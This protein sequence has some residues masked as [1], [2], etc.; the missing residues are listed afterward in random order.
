M[1]MYSS[2]FLIGA[3]SLPTYVSGTELIEVENPVKDKF[4]VTMKANGNKVIGASQA[5]R[6]HQIIAGPDGDDIGAQSHGEVE[7]IYGSTIEGFAATL[8]EVGLQNV[9]DSPDVVSVE[10]DGYV[11]IEVGSWGLDR[12]DDEDLPLD[13]SYNP[14]FGNSGAGVTAYIIDTGIFFS[15]DE[16]EG[17][18]T[19]EFNSADS[20]NEDC[21]GHGTHV[22]GT[23]GAKTYGV[24]NKVKLVGVKVLSCNGSGT[25]SGVIAGMDWV[26]ANANKPAT[27]NMSLGGGKSTASNA[28]VK[29]LVDSGIPTVV[30]AGNNNGDACN[31]SP[32]SEPTAITVGSTTSTDTRSSFSNWGTCV[33]VFAPGSDIKA[34]WIGSDAATKTIS[35]TSM[36]SPHV[37]GGVA[38]YLGQDPTLS[39]K[40]VVD[41]LLEDSIANTITSVGIG[42]P[43]QFLYVGGSK[44]PTQ[45][46]TNPPASAPTPTPLENIAKGKPTK[47]SSNANSSRGLSENAVDGNT[48]GNYK[49]DSVTHTKK[50]NKAWW[51]VDLEDNIAIGVVKVYNRDDCC[52]ERLDNFSL[53]I[54]NDDKEAWKY[55]HKGAAPQMTKITVP[56]K[57]IGDKIRVQLPGY[58]P[59]SLA[60]VEVFAKATN[61]KKCSTNGKKCLEVEKLN[62]NKAQGD[63]ILRVKF[64]Y[65][66]MQKGHKDTK[67]VVIVKGGKKPSQSN[68]YGI[69]NVRRGKQTFLFDMATLLEKMPGGSGELDIYFIK[70]GVEI[71]PETKITINVM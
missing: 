25:T 65:R 27:V 21:H 54:M 42:S 30:A 32:A 53:I 64:E 6:I 19:Q 44:A 55:E 1:V 36:A 15:H 18:A 16:F 43:N 10:Q 52:S 66:P 58:N 13:Q 31:K 67:Q 24:A 9:L 57:V 69:K 22:A 26:A 60:E 48:D 20:T 35:G 5:D 28:A 45:N 7:H 12:I 17:R 46:G 59:L 40:G 50:Q 39:P 11:N 2:L 61:I 3:I 34:P 49:A 4:I 14:T 70:E 33:D 68:T 62:F 51:E 8:D 37:C 56:G 29:R 71:F 47:Q 38:L 63:D 41:M 23:V